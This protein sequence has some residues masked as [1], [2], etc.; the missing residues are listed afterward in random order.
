M[1]HTCTHVDKRLLA[2]VPDQ[3]RVERLDAP[4]AANAA[5][6]PSAVA[7]AERKAP[8]VAPNEP[9]DRTAVEPSRGKR[10][11]KRGGLQTDGRSGAPLALSDLLPAIAAISFGATL[12]HA[13]YATSRPQQLRSPAETITCDSDPARARIQ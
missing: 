2:R 1:G 12:I 4:Q 8:S 13:G 6:P 3:V 9:T 11:K 5:L 7:R 10:P